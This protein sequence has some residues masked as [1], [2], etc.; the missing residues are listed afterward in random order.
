M[1]N[2]DI[3]IS[4]NVFVKTTWLVCGVISTGLGITG[5][6]LPVMPGTTFIIIALYCFA[7][8]SER[9]HNWLLNNKYF[10]QTLRDFKEGKGMTKKA[11]WSAYTC[12]LISICISLFFASNLWVSLFLIVCLVLA[13]TSIYRQKT[14]V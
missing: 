1:M 2:K 8:S 5:Y 3:N 4:K 6:M 14:R 11:K 12:V 10:G 7:R 13:I 9:Y